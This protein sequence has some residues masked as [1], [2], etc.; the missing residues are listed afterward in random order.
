MALRRSVANTVLLLPQSST[1]VANTND[2]AAN[3]SR[4][5][6]DSSTSASS[7]GGN[8]LALCLGGQVDVHS[9]LDDETA[10]VDITRCALLSAVFSCDGAA[11]AR[12][13]APRCKVR[14]VYT[15]IWSR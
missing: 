3:S 11:A 10:A 4:T 2:N 7:I 14:H 6:S 15:C 8:C 13:L 12:V 9:G 1:A 5:S